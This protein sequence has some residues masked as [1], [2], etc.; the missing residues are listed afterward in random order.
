MIQKNHSI[1]ATQVYGAALR[2]ILNDVIVLQ[3]HGMFRT[4]M[5]I[6][7]SLVTAIGRRPDSE[8]AYDEVRFGIEAL[9]NEFCLV[10]NWT[11]G[12]DE[13]G[14]DYIQFYLLPEKVMDEV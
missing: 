1:T 13:E 7:R 10:G 5:R 14:K 4:P 2:A 6:P 8:M 3:N 12:K 9:L 11:R